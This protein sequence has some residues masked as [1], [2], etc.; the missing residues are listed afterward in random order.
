MGD[1]EYGLSLDISAPGEELSVHG[2]QCRIQRG[3]KDICHG[4]REGPCLTEKVPM[5]VSPERSTNGDRYR[6]VERVCPKQQS[7]QGKPDV[8]LIIF[9]C[10]LSEC[11]VD[12][13]T[14]IGVYLRRIVYE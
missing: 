7:S 5:E 6:R 14:K 11:M 9:S 2:E 1:R 8:F 3:K 13:F 12:Y 10:H 4:K